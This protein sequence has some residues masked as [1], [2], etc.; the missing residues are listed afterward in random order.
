MIPARGVDRG[1]LRYGRETE[2][3]LADWYV[4]R[5]AGLVEVRLPWGVLNVTD[6][7]SRTV[8]T[9]IREGGVVLT[10]PTD[11]FRFVVAGLA[12]RHRRRHRVPAGRRDLYLADL[13]GA[14]VARAP[15]AR[16]LRHARSVGVV[17]T[18]RAAPHLSCFCSSREPC[19]P[20]CPR[21]RTPSTAA[22]TARRASLRFGAGLDSLNPR[23][24]YRLAVFD[25]WDGT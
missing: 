6:P 7:S 16:V 22:T 10:G 21:R 25:S 13:G 2:S 9:A 5:Q 23:A 8:L 19:P 1:R 18:R 11:G 3:S 15:E 24:L 14:D 17:V 4:D 20:S 12:A